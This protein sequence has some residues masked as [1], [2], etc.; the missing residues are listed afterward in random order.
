MCPYENDN[1]FCD[2]DHQKYKTNIKS[3]FHFN[4]NYFLDYDISGIKQ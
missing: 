1:A 2:E 4:L 3:H